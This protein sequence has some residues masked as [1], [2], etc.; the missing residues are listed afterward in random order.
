VAAKGM[1]GLLFA[2]LDD[3]TGNGPLGPSF[4]ARYV[5]LH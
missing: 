4:R 2:L 5:A 3:G 1:A